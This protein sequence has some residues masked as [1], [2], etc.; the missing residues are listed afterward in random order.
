MEKQID[1]HILLE[2]VLSL[3]SRLGIRSVTMDDISRQLGI[4]KKTIYQQIVD[5]EDLVRSVVEYENSLS[6]KLTEQFRESGINAIDQLI[7]VNGVMHAARTKHSPT[8]YYD[9]K[10]YHPKI[11]ADWI[12]KKRERMYSLLIRNMVRG[13]KEG[14]YRA[15]LNHHIIAR[16]YLARMEMLNSTD[17]IEDEEIKSMDFFREILIYHIHGICNSRGLDYFYLHKEQL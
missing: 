6:H 17:V 4:S 16:L 8:F 2:E 10:K 11:F 3:Y 1:N 9:L 7:E 15:D 13:K 12:R 5:K 14:L